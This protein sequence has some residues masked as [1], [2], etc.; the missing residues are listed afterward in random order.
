MRRWLEMGHSS[1]KTGN[2]PTRNTFLI[3]VV[4]VRFDEP[5]GKWSIVRIGRKE[6][7]SFI[8]HIRRVCLLHDIPVV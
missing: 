8:G 6:G 7:A 5:S 2:S 4:R 3:A 1:A